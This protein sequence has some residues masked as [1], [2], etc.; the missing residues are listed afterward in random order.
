MTSSRL[1]KE[2]S[3]NEIVDAHDLYNEDLSLNHTTNNDLL[4]KSDMADFKSPAG[5]RKRFID[6]F[7]SEKVEQ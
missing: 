6:T 4:D 3:A 2:M 7:A 1:Q 5:E